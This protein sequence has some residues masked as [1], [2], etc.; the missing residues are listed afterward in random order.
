MEKSVEHA[1]FAPLI[2][3]W[4]P[5]ATFIHIIRN[6]YA[7]LVASRNTDWQ[8]GY[9][10]LASYLES[11]KNSYCYLFKNIKLFENYLI[12]RYEDLVRDPDK[13]MNL[14]ARHTAIEMNEI[15]L[16]PTLCGE[17]WGGN[18][19][20]NKKFTG[21]SS[22]PSTKWLES[23]YDLEIILTN[24]VA[25]PIIEHFNYELLSPRHNPLRQRFMP[26]RG[27]NFNKYIRNRALLW[28]I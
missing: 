28:H 1:E 27:E 20:S 3:K 17:P 4:F 10:Y 24:K 5:D 26:I 21:V 7:T 14:I 6:P 11:L 9:P 16:Q 22:T 18:S 12:I 2:N 19:S 23:I 13:T 8:K 15:L 25:R